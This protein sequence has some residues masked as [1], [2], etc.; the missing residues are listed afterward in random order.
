MKYLPYLILFILG[1]ALGF[2]ISPK[3]EPIIIEAITLTNTDTIYQKI[4]VLKLKKDTIKIYYE[5]KN[6]DYRLMPTSKR[7]EL[8]ARRVNR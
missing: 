7:V 4:E 1:G 8:F 5:K 6:K 2:Y 3:P